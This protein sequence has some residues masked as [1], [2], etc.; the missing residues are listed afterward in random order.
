MTWHSSHRRRGNPTVREARRFFAGLL[1]KA[2]LLGIAVVALPP[3]ADAVLGLRAAHA[4]CRVVHVV[5]G[6]TV[7]FHCPGE[8]FVRTRLVGFDAPE[9]F[10]PGC[11]SEAA[12]ALAAQWHLRRTLWGAERLELVFAG[13][14]RYGRPLAEA[15][16]DG[17]RLAAVMIEA[18]HAR[19][20]G[21]GRREGW[22]A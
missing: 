2:G 1:R 9:L 7:D 22:C 20:Y 10:S 15:R 16:V 12:A 19:P 8:G 6:D 14:D 17:R 11:A 18:G 21:G 5:D 3:V 4:D 13:R